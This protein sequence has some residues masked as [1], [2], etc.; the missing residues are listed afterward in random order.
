MARIVPIDHEPFAAG[1]WA[2]REQLFL[3]DGR[4]LGAELYAAAADHDDC[5]VEQA[6]QNAEQG[7]DI[8]ALFLKISPIGADVAVN[9]LYALLPELVQM[10]GGYAAVIIADQPV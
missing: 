5:G 6:D 10:R 2:E 4:E 1:E 9:G 8:P 7:T 3:Y